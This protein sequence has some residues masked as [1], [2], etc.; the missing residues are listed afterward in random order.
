MKSK[1]VLNKNNKNA[2][3]DLKTQTQKFKKKKKP[4]DLCRWESFCFAWLQENTGEWSKLQLLTSIYFCELRI[5]NLHSTKL[6]EGFTIKKR[7]KLSLSNN[8]PA[9]SQQPNRE[10][11]HFYSLFPSFLVY[12][13]SFLIHFYLRNRRAARTPFQMCHWR[14]Q[15]TNNVV[16]RKIVKK[17]KIKPSKRK[18]AQRS[19]L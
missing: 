4:I 8:F 2:N 14:P 16:Q 3:L 5:Q 15:Q 17:K 6:K 1:C 10:C 9:F 7:T 11:F 12:P 19:I 13:E 18:Q